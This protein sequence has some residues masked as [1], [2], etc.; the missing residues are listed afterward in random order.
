MTEYMKAAVYQ[1][2]GRIE[3]KEVPKPKIGSKEALL[4]VKA[5]AI[6]GTDLR[7]F[8][9]GH[10]KVT[11]PRILGHE[12]AGEVVAIGRD[13]KELNVGERI[14]VDPLVPCGKCYWC[15]QGIHNLCDNA[16]AIA[17]DFDGGFAEYLRIPEE[18]ISSGGVVKLPEGLSYEGATIAE[19]LGCCIN[20]QER[21]NVK[22]GETVAIIGAGPIG[23]LHLKLV[24]AINA[25]VIISEYIEARLK[26]AREFGADVIIN[27][28]VE[29]PIKRV[30]EETGG[31]GADVVIVAC[32]S[33]VAQQQSLEMAAKRGRI[34]FFGGLPH[35]KPIIN[36]NS[37]IIHYKEQNVMGSFSLTPHQFRK[38][39]DLITAGVIDVKSIITDTFPLD[40]IIDALKRAESKEGLKIIIK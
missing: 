9:C 15:L 7:I 16:K 4:R 35:E 22:L 30:L 38:A 18:V 14:T 31:K 20:G 19:P 33:P 8:R 28:K 11:P 40:N 34:V 21:A 17:Y 32:P 26:R 3:I 13:V 37:N 10:H 29:N 2:V 1:G 39:V 25:K 36:L 24:K 23:C 5:C 6:C 12:V 27:S